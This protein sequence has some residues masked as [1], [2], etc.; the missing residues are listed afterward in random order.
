MRAPKRALSLLG[1]ARA[2]MDAD[3]LATA[4]RA[5]HEL[6]SIWHAADPGIRA[7]EE[8]RRALDHGER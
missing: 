6:S 5:Y 3:D 4:E 8:A 2:A 7:L 1:L